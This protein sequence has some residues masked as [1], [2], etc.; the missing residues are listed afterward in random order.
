[1]SALRARPRVHRARQD[2][3]VRRLLPRARGRPARRGRLRR[4]HA[5]HPRLA[6]RAGGHGRGHPR[7]PLQRPRGGRARDRGARPGP[8]P[9]S[10][11]SRWPATWAAW[12]RA[13]AT[14]RGCA[15]WPRAAG[16]LLIFDE[17]MTG[18]RLVLRRGAGRSSASRRT[19]PAWARSSAAACPSAPTAAG[20]DVMEHIAPAGPVYQAGT[21]SGN[22]L[23]MAAGCATLDA[24]AARR[25]AT[26]GWRCSP[27]RLHGRP[28]AGPR[29][30]A[31]VKVDHQPRGLDDHPLLHPGP[32]DRLR[33]R[34]D[35]RHRALR[36][37][38]PRLLARGVYFPP[39]Q[40]EAA[41]VSLA[42]S[43]SDIDATVRAAGE[44]FREL[45][46]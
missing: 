20:A 22:P 11:W 36:A 43:E 26:S 23:A 42:H 41:F 30:E 7:R 15:T 28:A 46:A 10:S 3:Q 19:S 14:C 8:A 17:V 39:A 45:R 37:L 38:L 2:P 5:G 4:G 32:G 35:L 1:M 25:D 27:A 16:A 12:P 24:P 34:E 31:D 29:D 6:G 44:I 9:P 21:L 13:T 18:F 33:E 40:F